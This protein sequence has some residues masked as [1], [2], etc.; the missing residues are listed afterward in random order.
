MRA[1]RL[2]PIG[3]IALIAFAA[4]APAAEPRPT[5]AAVERGEYLVN[6]LGCARCHTEGYLTGQTPSGPALAGSRIGIA[7]SAYTG[8]DETPGL[9]FSPNLT[10]D[11][12]TGLGRWSQEDIV[13]AMRTGV[14][15][16]GH[17]NLPVMPSAN[18]AALKREDLRAIAAYLKSLAP[19]ARVIPART[20][21]G[22]PVEFPYVRFG[23]YRF[24]P[25]ASAP[26]P[27]GPGPSGPGQAPRELPVPPVPT[28]G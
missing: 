21:P 13:R 12:D 15:R 20:A 11:P 4:S 7:W 14:S 28:G 23:V 22:A 18:Y 6:L 1:I 24:E 27:S 5:R 25:G 9:A 26:G 8:P 10:P 3:L 2:L 17:Q 19:V 16:D